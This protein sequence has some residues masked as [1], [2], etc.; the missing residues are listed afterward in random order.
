MNAD[1]CDE[2]YPHVRKSRIKSSCV[3]IDPCQRV[4]K[5]AGKEMSPHSATFGPTPFDD[6]AEGIWRSLNYTDT[7]IVGCQADFGNGG[8]LL[9]LLAASGTVAVKVFTATGAEAHTFNPAD[10]FAI[11]VLGRYDS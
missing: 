11:F 4:F 3:T 8:S 1:R 7:T 5:S 9:W 6:P 2:D 10:D